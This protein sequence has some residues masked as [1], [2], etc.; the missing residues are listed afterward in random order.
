MRIAVITDAHANLPALE[1][2]LRAI[3]REGCDLIVHTGDALAIGPY[4]AECL[5]LLLGTRDI[6]LVM[7][8]HESWFVDGL[9][10][11]Q[12][13]WMSDGEREH[14]E[15]MHAQIDPQLRSVVAQW[16]YALECESGGVLITFVHYAL[17][18]CSRDFIPPTRHPTPSDLDR[19]FAHHGTAL[20]FYGHDHS[21]SDAEG[22]ARYV[23]PGSLGCCSE[24]VARY[25]IADMRQGSYT[26]SHHAVTYDDGA[27]P[28]AFEERRVPARDF[29]CQAFFGGRFGR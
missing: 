13:A 24:P 22:R 10:E 15:W 19:M 3:R 2:A 7:G 25:C 8:N 26:I 20:I 17:A 9:P 14:Q 1:A 4:P 6:R 28:G 21:A 5:D 12:P 29:I 18:P 27:L 23:N 11:P 16:P